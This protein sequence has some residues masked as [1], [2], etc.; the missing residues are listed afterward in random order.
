[1]TAQIDILLATYNGARFLPEQLQSLLDQTHRD[2]R[3]LINLGAFSTYLA[4]RHR[5]R[6]DT[7]PLVQTHLTVV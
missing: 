4:L 6:R 5:S 2:W 3:K 7:L 1:M